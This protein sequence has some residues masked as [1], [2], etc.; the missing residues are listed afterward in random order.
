M[1]QRERESQNR[2]KKRNRK[3]ASIFFPSPNFLEARPIKHHDTQ[4]NPFTSHKVAYTTLIHT[5]KTSDI[6]PS[7]MSVLIHRVVIQVIGHP[8]H[9]RPKRGLQVRLPPHGVNPLLANF[10]QEARRKG[11]IVCADRGR[12]R[13]DLWLD[14]PFL[15]RWRPQSWGGSIGGVGG[16]AQPGISIGAR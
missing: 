4:Y 9:G 14:G 15:V 6:Y 7:T 3:Q 12:T 8:S 5:P 1:Q 13:I 16:D 2:K 11:E 10:E